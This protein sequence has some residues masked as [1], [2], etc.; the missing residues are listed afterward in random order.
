MADHRFLCAQA[1]AREAG[2][3]IR[4]RFRDR[5][6]FKLAYKGHQDHV[7]EVDGEA[8]RLIVERLSEAFAGDTFMG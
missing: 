6:S 8:E 1:V 5:S 2:Q 4:R 7:T 3:L